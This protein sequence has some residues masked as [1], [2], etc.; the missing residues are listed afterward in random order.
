M[1]RGDRDAYGC[2][3]LCVS[4][5]RQPVKSEKSEREVRRKHDYQKEEY[6]TLE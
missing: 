6:E 1:Q 3:F 5:L 2:V 4:A